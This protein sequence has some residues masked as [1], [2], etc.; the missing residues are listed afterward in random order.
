MAMM[1][2]SL[3]DALRMAGSSDEPTRKA[4]D[5]VAQY[6][7]RFGKVEAKLGI[8]KWMVGFNLAISAAVSAKL[9]T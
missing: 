6:E 3:Y 2:S 7:N 4:A 5:Q 1:M 9:L 8:L